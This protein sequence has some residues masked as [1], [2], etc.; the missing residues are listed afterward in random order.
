MSAFVDYLKRMNR[1]VPPSSN[2]AGFLT[3]VSGPPDTN[4]S[5]FYLFVRDTLTDDIYFTPNRD[6]VWEIA[7]AGSYLDTDEGRLK[8]TI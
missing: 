7:L 1:E 2:F 6:G 5:P 8:V 3:E 4:T